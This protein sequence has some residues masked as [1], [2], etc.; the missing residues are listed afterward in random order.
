MKNKNKIMVSWSQ[1]KLWRECPL[2]WKLA[3]IDKIKIQEPSIVL[4]F[5]TSIHEIVQQYLITLYTKTIS[6]ANALELDKLLI[7]RMSQNYIQE[8]MNFG[9]ND[10]CTK[11]EMMEFFYD[12]LKII[13][14]LKKN[15]DKY[16]PKK[17][18]ELLGVE[19]KLKNNLMGGVEFVGYIDVIIRDVKN[20]KIKIY[21]LKTSINGWNKYMKVDKMRTDQLLLYKKYY[22]A[23]FNIPLDRIDVEFLI[24]KRKL[25]ENFDF[26]QKRF[27]IVAP[28][29]GKIS[30]NKASK[31]LDQFMSEN[32]TKSGQYNINKNYIATPNK[33]SCKYCEFKNTKYCKVGV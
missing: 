31:Y 17:D 10:F 15:R 29:S 24:F 3:Y 28:A 20:S 4:I 26:P 6:E 19:L 9:G 33:K 23:Q 11:S 13:D 25:F 32:F 14:F 1:L 16:F 21:D 5:G 22:A 30:L 18:H 27:Q 7:E 12:G 2:H 8:K